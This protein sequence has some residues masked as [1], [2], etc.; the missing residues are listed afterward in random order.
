[1][2]ITPDDFIGTWA[3]TQ[4]YS[5]TK[6]Q[7][8]ID[9][10]STY[11]LASLLGIELFNDFAVNLDNPPLT[12]EFQKINDSFVYQVN[13]N[14]GV[15]GVIRSEGLK[16]M[17]LCLVYAHYRSEDLGTPTSGGQIKL[18]SEGGKLADD[19]WSNV[20]KIYNRGIKSYRAIQKYI[21]DNIDSYEGYEG[22]D[23]QTS[24]LI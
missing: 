11:Y 8:Y 10:Y 5:D 18:H 12:A 16:N 13:Y 19:T 6:L 2:I 23:K 24:W 3:I 15:N 22:V 4:G 17:L 21:K 7:E 14:C 1:M 9:Y 20:Y